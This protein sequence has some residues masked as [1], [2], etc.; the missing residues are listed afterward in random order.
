VPRWK[1]AWVERDGRIWV[2]LAWVILTLLFFSLSVGKRG[3]YIFPALP[4]LAIAAAPFLPDIFRR[5]GVQ[6]A[7]VIVAAILILAA[8]G[9]LVAE[10]TGHEKLHAKLAEQGVESLAPIAVFVALGV[11]ALA[12]SVWKK[13]ILAWPS[14]L[15]GVAIVWSYG[16]TPVIDSER[17]ARGFMKQMLP[18]VPPDQTLGLYSYKEQ[19]LL[20][21]DRPIV[22]FGHSRWREGE[23]EAYDA[24]VWLSGGK[25]R[26]LLIPE[27]AVTPCFV[28]TSKEPAGFSSGDRWL[29]VRGTPAEACLRKGDASRAIRYQPPVAPEG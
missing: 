24:S 4:G 29:L 19:F 9:L 6:R 23:Q 22:N 28:G 13:P 20:Y 25:D 27:P 8:I 18:L 1:A 10:A 11:A 21:L 16:I 3:I 26:V 17:S 2:P 5:R 14:V 7:S 15:A 12:A